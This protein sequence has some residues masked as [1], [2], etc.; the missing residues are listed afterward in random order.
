MISFS[1][2]ERE[3]GLYGNIKNI[4]IVYVPSKSHKK[5]SNAKVPVAYITFEDSQQ[6][7]NAQKHLMGLMVGK[8]SISVQLHMQKSSSSNTKGRFQPY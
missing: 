7:E 6:A 2:L 4:D 3:F 8:R 1:A 5:K